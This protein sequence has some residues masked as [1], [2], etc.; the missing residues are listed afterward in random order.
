[1]KQ[2]KLFVRILCMVLAVLMLLSV[3]LLALPARA[4]APA[5]AITAQEQLRD[6]NG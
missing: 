2:Q 5:E 4:H 1:M 6:G 3:L